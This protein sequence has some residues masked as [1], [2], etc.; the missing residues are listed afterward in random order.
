MNIPIG[1][2]GTYT[3]PVGTR[4]VPYT[5]SLTGANKKIE[6]SADYGVSW[7]EASIDLATAE[8]ISV[9]INGGLTS[10]RFTADPGATWRIL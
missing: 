6:L 10:I 9:T 1:P 3:L 5:V 4:V 2:S 7:I 8:T